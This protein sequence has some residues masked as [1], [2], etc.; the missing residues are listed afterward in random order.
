MLMITTYPPWSYSGSRA[1]IFDDCLRKYYYHYYGSHN[2][3][4]LETAEPDQ[5]QTYRLKQLSNLYLVFGNLAHQMCESVIRSWDKE[6]K[7][8]EAS[9]LYQ[10]MRELLNQAYKESQDV[11]GWH[12]RP[13]Y[14]TM[15]SEIYYD[16]DDKLK[17][18]ISSIKS[19]MQTVV[20]KLYHTRTWKEVESGAAHIMEIE[21]WDHMILHDT[22]VYVKM[23]VLYRNEQG[24]IVIV[25]WKTGKEN[26]FTDQ[27]YLYALYVHEH[28][29]VPYEHIE[30]RVEYLLTGECETYQATQQDIDKVSASTLRYIEEMKSCLADDYY[31]RPKDISFFT[32]MPS[33]RVCGECNFREIC[34]SRAV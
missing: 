30:M 33:R 29:N 23:D 5:V 3:W 16:E 32:P 26:D 24:H 2:G 8:P 21:K 9:F 17:D 27:L 22:R 25:D 14:Q 4:K 6:R 34:S 11:T 18:R 28:Y 7:V 15:L 12:L 13:K 1:A 19:R 20:D 10:K 31:N